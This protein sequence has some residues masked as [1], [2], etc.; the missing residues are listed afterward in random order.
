MTTLPNSEALDLE[1]DGSWL[2]VWFNEPEI[3]NPLTEARVN[4]LHELCLFLQDRRDIRGVMFR[5]R[6]AVFCAG[7]DLKAIQKL[8][9]GP[10]VRQEIIGFSRRVGLLMQAINALP[11]ITIMAVEGAAI[12]GGFGFICLGDIIIS[13]EET[14]FSLTETR[15]GL[16]PAQVAPFVIQRLGFKEARRLMLTGANFRGKEALRIGLVDQVTKGQEEIDMAIQSVKK[17]VMYCA[18]E[19]VAETKKLL[20]GI[21]DLSQIDATNLAAETF[22]DR[23]LSKE[24]VDGVLSFVQRRKPF[25]QEG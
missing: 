8:F 3:R 16:S 6:G 9:E 15:I 10:P 2:N 7:A 22:A 19:A 20:L 13:D 17:E 21:Q 24:G 25:W 12:A 5:G 18:P 14:R 1:V 23:V 4:D 11:Q